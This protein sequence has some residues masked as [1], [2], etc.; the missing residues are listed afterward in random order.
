MENVEHGL[1]P[2]SASTAPGSN[3]ISPYG[4]R[5]NLD[6]TLSYRSSQWFQYNRCGNEIETLIL[7]TQKYSKYDATI[8][9]QTCQNIPRVNLI[10]YVK[11]CKVSIV[12]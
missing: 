8:H 10:Y 3:D 11:N 1:T 6:R 4:S 9:S 7:A 12:Y 2:S 5:E